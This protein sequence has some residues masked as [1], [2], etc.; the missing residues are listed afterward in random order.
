MLEYGSAE[1][2]DQ[3]A[4][5]LESR[6]E[7]ESEPFIFL[8]PE[9]CDAFEKAVQGDT[10]YKQ[11]ARNWE[12]SVV[13]VMLT[14][15]EIGHQNDMFIFMDLWH[16]ECN[17]LSI[18]PETKGRSGEFVLEADYSRWKQI[19]KGELNVVKE[20]ATRKLKLSPFDIKKAMKLAAASQAA[21]RL[22][23]LAGSI[24]TVFLDELEGEAK[25]SCDKLFT[26]LRESF[27][28]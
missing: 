4:R 2:G 10:R 11:V 12:G 16:G 18:V 9:W 27:G 22:V 15:P 7:S 8:S 17:Y 26:E 28:I 24:P 1:Y 19:L 25:A 21:I 6:K 13:L 5:L 20:L 23:E 14:D 3:Y